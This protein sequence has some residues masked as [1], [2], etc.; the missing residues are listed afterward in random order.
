MTSRL[1]PVPDT[2]ARLWEEFL[3]SSEPGAGEARRARYSAWQFGT[4]V[5]QGNRLLE[6]V[7]SGPKRATAGALWAFEHEGEALPEAEDYSIVLD[8]HG[9]ARCIIRTTEVRI[10]PFNEVDAQFAYDEGEG[11]RS[12]EYWRAVHWEYFTRE[13]GEMGLEAT[14]AMPVVCERFEV[15][16]QLESDVKVLRQ[17]SA[18]N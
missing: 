9:I 7:L 15:V 17:F 3:A 16:F 14:E 11:D 18:Q 13:L 5:E 6:Y 2:A 1:H 12:L 4:G 10:V 8:G